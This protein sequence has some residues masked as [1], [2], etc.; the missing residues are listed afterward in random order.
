M[1]EE[2]GACARLGT[3]IIIH[4]QGKKFDQKLQFYYSYSPKRQN[5][6]G[7]KSLPQHAAHQIKLLLLSYFAFAAFL[8]PFPILCFAPSFKSFF[9]MPY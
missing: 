7:L 8:L 5:T 2:C 9:V 4:R 3:I 6:K 1:S